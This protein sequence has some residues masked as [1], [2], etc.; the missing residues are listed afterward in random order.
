[1]QLWQRPLDQKSASSTTRF[2]HQTITASGRSKYCR[3]VHGEEHSLKVV[4]ILVIKMLLN[5]LRTLSSV[6]FATSAYVFRFHSEI[7]GGEGV[8]L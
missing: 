6:H 7:M 2:I 8:P 5:H 1:M 4:I 3:Q